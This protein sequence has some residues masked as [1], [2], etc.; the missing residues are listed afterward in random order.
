MTQYWTDATGDHLASTA[1]NWS[2][3]AFVQGDQLIVDGVFAP[4]SNDA[5]TFNVAPTDADGSPLLA[6]LTIPITYSGAVNFTQCPNFTNAFLDDSGA[7]VDITAVG[8]ILAPNITLLGAN[9]GGPGGLVLAAAGS[10]TI[11]GGT[12]LSGIVFTANANSSWT[13][14]T[15]TFNN[16]VVVNYGRATWGGGDVAL[17]NGTTIANW[18]SFQ[19]TCDQTM[20]T[21]GGGGFWNLGYFEKEVASLPLP[22]GLGFTDIQ[23]QFNNAVPPGLTASPSVIIDADAFLML[24]GT[25]GTDAAPFTVNAGGTLEFEGGVQSLY[26]GTSFT[27]AGALFVDGATLNLVDGSNLLIS[28]ASFSFGRAGALRRCRRLT[29]RPRLAWEL[30]MVRSPSR[31]RWNGTTAPS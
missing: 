4:H 11:G 5:L 3:G 2:G 24:S 14:G 8:T 10:A 26:G 19:I 17:N 29:E 25:G 18:G 27:G 7:P 22:G 21:V 31:V 13:L 16:D 20:S 30:R 23:V 15:T 12:S 1:G 9:V 6:S 28:T